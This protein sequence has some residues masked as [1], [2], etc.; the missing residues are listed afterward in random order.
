MLFGLDNVKSRQKLNKEKAT[1]FNKA[2]EELK[3]KIDFLQH[4]LDSK[5]DKK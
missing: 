3:K 4:N 5:F 2:T 1:Q